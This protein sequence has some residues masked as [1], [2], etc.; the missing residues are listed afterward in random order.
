MK[1]VWSLWLSANLDYYM[2]KIFK[3]KKGFVSSFHDHFYCAYVQPCPTSYVLLNYQAVLL[4]TTLFMAPW[5]ALII[6]I[7]PYYSIEF[8]W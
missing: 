7:T 1:T 5:M 2:G 3:N 6:P 8:K 4:R